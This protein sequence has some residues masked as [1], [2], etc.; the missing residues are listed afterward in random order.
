M[1][2][3]EML[4]DIIVVSEKVKEVLRFA[5]SCRFVGSRS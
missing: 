1:T 3:N 5:R 2:D 4:F